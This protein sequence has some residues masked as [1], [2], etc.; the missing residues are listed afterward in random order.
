MGCLGTLNKSLSFPIKKKKKKATKTILALSSFFE[1][2]DK[3]Q[4]VREI[5]SCFASVASVSLGDGCCCVWTRPAINPLS[6]L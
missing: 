3:R 4:R 5:Y 1:V 2:F 6:R